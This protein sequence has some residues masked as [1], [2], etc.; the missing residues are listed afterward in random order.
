MTSYDTEAVNRFTRDKDWIYFGGA[1]KKTAYD[2]IGTHYKY[3]C[4]RWK[5]FFRKQPKVPY[6]DRCV[7]NHVITQN[8][9]IL[10]TETK[11]I[12]I[13]GNCCI[14]K[15]GLQGKTCSLCNAIHKNRKDNYCNDCRVILALAKK[16][17]EKKKKKKELCDCGRKKT[18]P[19]MPKCI[20][21]WKNSQY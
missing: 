9:Y 14:K 20:T 2:T 5:D 11:D 15:F 3:F 19:Q 12:K 7:C 13:I 16:K 8:C 18:Y 1:E 17:E 6:E 21:C 10:N 4:Q